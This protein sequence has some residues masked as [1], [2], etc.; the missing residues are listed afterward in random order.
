L[1][2]AHAVYLEAIRFALESGVG[3]RGSC[4]VLDP[5]GD[6]VHDKLDDRWRIATEDKSFREKVLET[7][8]TSAGQVYH[9]WVDRRPIPPSEAWFETA[10]AN[11]RN[12]EIFDP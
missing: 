9:T 1:C 2:F 6:R 5:G 11:F 4:I 3:S 10:W 7:T 12:G 8:A